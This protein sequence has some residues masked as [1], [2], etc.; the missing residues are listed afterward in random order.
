MTLTSPTQ[1]QAALNQYATGN[2]SGVSAI[3]SAMPPSFM[4]IEPDDVSGEP[5]IINFLQDGGFRSFTTDRPVEPISYSLSWQ[6]RGGK[7][8]LLGQIKVSP[9]GWTV[10]AIERSLV[11]PLESFEYATYQAA[12]DY[13][14]QQWEQV[15]YERGRQAVRDRC[16]DAA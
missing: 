4:P 13:L 10:S 7:P 9:G 11:P 14:F 12:A 6:R 2:L 5:R 8:Q 15:R 3:A 16:A 1:A